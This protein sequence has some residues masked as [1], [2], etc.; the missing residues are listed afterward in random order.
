MTTDIWHS[1]EF[2]Y[3]PK[4]V[5][6]RQQHHNYDDRCG[7]FLTFFSK[8]K[9]KAGIQMGSSSGS[10][11]LFKYGC[12]SAVSTD[13]LSRGLNTNILLNKSN[14]LRDASGYS[15]LSGTGAF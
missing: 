10:W 8:S 2:S 6:S 15:S 7:K 3:N 5:G 1:F 13:I 11:Y 12:F 4:N 14:A 9:L